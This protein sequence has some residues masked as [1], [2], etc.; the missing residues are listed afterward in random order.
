[1]RRSQNQKQFDK[2]NNEFDNFFLNG[3]I[4][5]DNCP[6]STTNA[7][8]DHLISNC[9]RNFP[10]VE[11]KHREFSLKCPW[12]DQT[13]ER[14]IKKKYQLFGNYKEGL[15]TFEMFKEYRNLLPKAIELARKI[16]F[17][18]KFNHLKN[19]PKQGWKV[20]NKYRNRKKDNTKFRIKIN[21]KEVTENTQHISN[22]FSKYYKTSVEA[23]V[24][25]TTESY[26]DLTESIDIHPNSMFFYPTDRIEIYNI[27][28]EL[29]PN[30]FHNSEIPTLLLKSIN[31]KLSIMLEHIFNLCFEKNVIPDVLKIALVMPIHKKGSKQLVE[32]FRPISILNPIAKIL[33]KLMYTR[34]LSFFT[35]HKLLT[36]YQ[37][38]FLKDKST[39]NATL[40]FLYDAYTSSISHKETSAVFIDLQKAFDTVITLFY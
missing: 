37:F 5:A 30:N 2:F 31:V 9:N 6:I 33:E 20:I 39:E 11:M 38:G 4:F 21:S 19:D 25:S 26:C 15:I 18:K 12:I 17:L 27:I 14:C 40:T 28:N 8:I 7:L 35:K 16:F 32:N 29:K 24:N 36:E 22:K 1:M 13:L 34:L 23:L 3:N 10:R